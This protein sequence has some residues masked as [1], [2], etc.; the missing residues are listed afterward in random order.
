MDTEEHGPVWP[1]SVATQLPVFRSH[2]LSVPSCPAETTW[3]LNFW[4]VLCARARTGPLWPF[5]SRTT[6]ALAASQSRTTPS[7]PAVTTS[8]SLRAKMADHTLPFST[9]RR[10]TSLPE[11][12]S[13]S[14][15]VPSAEDESSRVPE[16]PKRT[17]YT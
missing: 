4:M 17:K 8:F 16:E 3:W 13:H 10:L 9:L 7:S 11:G 15:A 5:I 14:R 6:L 1:V 12:Y 2:T